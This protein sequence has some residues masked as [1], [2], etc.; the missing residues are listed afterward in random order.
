MRNIIF[1]TLLIT[2]LIIG[3]GCSN[4]IK[5]KQVS[6]SD[7]SIRYAKG[8]R[9]D[10]L[11]G[12]S[13]I[14][15]SDP[16]GE[17]KAVYKYVFVNKDSINSVNIPDV[18]T[19]IKVPIERAICMTTLQISPF[20]KLSETKRIAGITSTRFLQNSDINRR[21]KSGD[22]KRIGIEGEF[23]TEVIYDISPDIILTS[24]FK[25]GGYNS[26]DHLDIPM[27]NYLGYKESSPL[28]Q[29]EWIKLIGILTGREQ[30][31]DSIFRDI[32]TKYNELRSEERRVG[33][34]C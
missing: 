7:Q 24:P 1:L 8:F 34:E 5:V 6:D 26:I 2:S 3:C 31:A 9:I 16:T 21:I 15:I 10:S 12:C 30:Q 33:K 11:S 22:V 18:Y 28:G 32:E 19:T 4:N 27:M 13:L 17:S 29:A 23:D 25:R 20:I 14:E